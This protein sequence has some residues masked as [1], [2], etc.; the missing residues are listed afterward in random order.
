M[1][2]D[3]TSMNVFQSGQMVNQAE[4][5]QFLDIAQIRKKPVAIF[6]LRQ[7]QIWTESEPM[8]LVP[9]S[10]KIWAPIPD[11]PF[12]SETEMISF[13]RSLA[14]TAIH[15]YDNDFMLLFHCIQGIS[16][17]TTL[18]V[19]FR[20][21]KFGY[22]RDEAYAGIETNRPQASPNVVFW[23]LLLEIER[24]ELGKVVSK[25]PVPR[26]FGFRSDFEWSLP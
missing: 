23:N 24:M 25:R 16:R 8:G 26:K 12:E 7:V 14:Q 15:F 6:D 19:A 4:V 17:S 11:R 18:N 3:E 1:K 5:N 21:M 22:S 9:G 10:V 20:M 2:F 13:F